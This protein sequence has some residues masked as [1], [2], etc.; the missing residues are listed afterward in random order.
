MEYVNDDRRVSYLEEIGSNV[1]RYPLEA[2]GIGFLTGFLFGGGQQS[3]IGQ[4][5]IG[6]AARFAVRQAAVTALSQSMRR[7]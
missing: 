3:R 2:L 7:S 5:L 6:V 1:R 4:V